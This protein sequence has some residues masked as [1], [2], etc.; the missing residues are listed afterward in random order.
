MIEHGIIIGTEP[1][2]SASLLAFAREVESMGY[3]SL[4]LPELFGREP[5]ATASY[6][7]ARTT[8]LKLATGIANVY[9]RD[10]HCMAQT[11]QTLAELSD[12]R[13]ILGL[14]VSNVGLNTAR[15]HEWQAPLPMMTA[16]LDAMAA[17]EVTSP[18]PAN[19]GPLYI[20]AHGPRLQA[21]GARRTDGVI[22]YLMT[23][24]HTRE[25]R[26]RI[27]PSAALNAVCPL[28]LETDPTRARARSRAQLKYYLTL[29]YYHREWRKLGFTDA[30]FADG[31]SDHLVD[32]IVGWGDTGALEKRVTEYEEAGATRVIV[33]P[34]DI[35]GSLE[36]G[37]TTLRALSS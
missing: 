36:T 2:K 17:A 28:L 7:L 25:S 33:M 29:D 24:Q 11:R 10:A 19:P 30:D 3:D 18:A 5:V 12:G 14:G 16:Y 15:G 20:A 21:L 27:G 23:P 37:M 13:F 6:L 9:V 26:A 35:D 1:F 32:S 8:T 22:T 31:G 4:W 34:L